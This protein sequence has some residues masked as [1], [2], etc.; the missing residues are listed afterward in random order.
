[1]ENN[2]R[3]AELNQL[4]ADRLAGLFQ[5]CLA[6]ERWARELADSRPYAGLDSLLT[7]ADELS[8]GLTDEEIGH[9]LGDHPRIGERVAPGTMPA[10]EQSGVDSVTLA[11]R[12]LAA[13]LAYERRFGHIY[14]VCASGRSGEELLADVAARLGNDPVTELAVVRRELGKIARL[15]LARMVSV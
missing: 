1:M 3:I 13:N 8:A 10:A 5:Q 15:R 11:D 12:L 2:F 9:A 7:R 6:V 4:G 14:L